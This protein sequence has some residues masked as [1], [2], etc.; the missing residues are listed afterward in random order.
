MCTII[1]GPAYTFG[2]GSHALTAT[3]TDNAGNQGSATTTFNVKVSSVSLCNLVTQFSTSSDVAA[4]LCDKLPAASQ[5]AARGQSKTKSNILRAF[6]KQ[7]SV[8]TGKALT[9]EQ[10]AVLNNLATAV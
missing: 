10:A 9:S 8:Q 3:A 6:D 7:V 2:L 1:T 4:G 5:A